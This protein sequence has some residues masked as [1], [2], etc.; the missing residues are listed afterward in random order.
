MRSLA[1]ARA[2]AALPRTAALLGAVALVSVL[3]PPA[4][5]QGSGAARSAAAQPPSIEPTPQTDASVP[6]RNVTMIGATP[7]ESEAPGR[8]ETWGVGQPTDTAGAVVVRYTSEGGWAPAPALLDAG[9][10]PLSGFKLAPSPLAGEMTPTGSGVLVGTVGKQRLVLVRKPH[11]A[12]QQTAPV[13]TEGEVKAGEAPLLKAGE[14][15]FA[16]GRAPLIAALDEAG[17]EAGALVVPM[18]EHEGVEGGVLHW[19]GERWTRE[20]IEIP[21]ASREDFRVLAIGA[22]SPSNA[23]LLAQLSSKSTYPQG[24][25]ALFRRVPGVGAGA[26]WSWK[27]VALSAGAGD[28]EAHPLTVPVREGAPA[29]LTVRGTGEPPTVTAQVLTVTSEGVWVDGE[30]ADVHTRAPASTTIFFAPEGLAKPGGTVAGTVRASWCELPSGAPA[31]TPQCDHELP[32][33][34]PDGPSRSIAWANPATPFG[35]RVVTGLSEGV[36]LRLN[37]ESFTRVLALGGSPPAGS[38]TEPGAALGAAFSTPNEGWLGEFTLP[39]HITTEPARSRLAQWPVPFRHPLVA[40]APQPGAPVGALS[41]EALAV[42]DLGAVARYKPGE[43][44]LPESLFGP[45]ERVE[46]PRLRAVAWP[47]PN[48]AYAVG[49]SGQMWLWRGET[50]LWERDPA[51]PL[52]FRGNLLGIAFDPNNAAR[53]YAVGS[54]EVGAGGVLLRYG[55]TWTQEEALPAEVQGASFTSIAFSGSEAIVAYRKLPDPRINRYVGGLLVN[56]GSGWRVDRG[57][58]GALGENAPEAVAG[59]PDGGAAFVASGGLEGPHVYEREAAGAPWQSKPMPGF[60]GGSLALF[61]EGGVLRAVTAGGG[62]GS[63]YA[64]ESEPQSPPGLPPILIGPYGIVGGGADSGGILRQTASGWSDE[65][66]ELNPANEVSGNYSFHDVPYRPDPILAVLIDPTDT[67]G[68]AVGGDLGSEASLET[69]E[70][71]RY[72]ADGVAPAGVGASQVPT[73]SEDATFAI[74]GGAQCAAPCADRARAGIGPDVWLGAALARA[75]QISGVRAFLYTGPRVATGET[76]GLKTVPIPFGREF[77]RYAA[78]LASSPLPVYAAASPQDLNAR[79]E[80]QGTEATFERV[81]DGFQEPFGG[82]APAA[83]LPPAP[84]ERLSESERQQCA[85]EVGCEAA[86]YAMDSEGSAGAVRII[87]LD[88]SREVDP[89]Q[90]GWLAGRL[91]DAGKEGKPAIVVGAADLNAQITAGDV[92]AAAVAHALYSGGASAY[93]YDAREENVQAPLLGGDGSIKEFGSG[94]L[95]YVNVV[96]ERFGDFHGASGFLLGQVDVAARDP[97]TN[98]APVSA[99]LIPSI[100]ELALEAKEGILLRRSEPALFDGLARRPRAGTRAVGGSDRSEVDPYIPI[101]SNCVG[102]VCATALLPEYTFSSS[103]PDIG[104]FVKPNLA[105]SN[106]RAVEQG[107]DGKPIPDPQSGLFCAYNAGTTIVTVSAGGLSSSLPV[108]VQAGSVRQPC[109]TVPLKELTAG[110]QST[111]AP[112]PPPAPAPGPASP[113]SSSP[114]P[115]VPIP[116]APLAAPPAP[117]SRPTPA[118]PAPFFLPPALATPVLAFVPPPVPTPARPTPPSG[119]SAV[120]SPIEVAEHEEEEEEAT[121][122]VSNQ[123]LAYRAPEH[124]PSSLYILG[125]VLLAAF[126]GASTRRRMRGGRRDLR[127]APATLTSMRAQRRTT[128]SSRRHR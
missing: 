83:G 24:A 65:G 92:Q 33:A 21:A 100:D 23:W 60:G 125:I 61:R 110:S 69:G 7:L 119:T 118:P 101:P 123:A 53:G 18:Y 127:V 17:G 128:A 112:V 124:E 121:E 32:E 126:A 71:A 39:V 4:V 6:A 99:R 122:S 26:S 50:G 37:G 73:H 105:S 42:G 78:V 57:A 55:K 30:R 74:G 59:L 116:P 103:R 47:T 1:A 97:L 40:I 81:F 63:N 120:T 52:N 98:R 95:G 22:G 41:S 115:V 91:D 58:A 15:L 113:P 88:D 19:D 76:S 72:P 44:W 109:G 84:G 46:T 68:W 108:T 8:N 10:Q 48:R 49:D 51:T 31:G 25:V 35:E 16:A 82:G 12:F 77:E 2:R 34:I 86:Y 102:S 3:A 79:P 38:V 14:A 93:F 20:S 106:S 43:G 9:G 104:D 36:S 114:P 111:P 80:S 64:N 5:L 90:L 75:G 107:L 56:D 96:K 27:P 117:P 85:G 87:V 29:P 67:Q 28:A 89:T 54:S 94:T 45:G 62:A 66:H 11:S 13:P 70:V